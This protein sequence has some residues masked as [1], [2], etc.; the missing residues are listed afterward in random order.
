MRLNATTGLIVVI[1]GLMIVNYG[2][3]HD[4]IW[5]GAEVIV[6]GLQSY[7]V[8]LVGTIITLIGAGAIMRAGK[9]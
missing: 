9:P 4:L 7:L 6:M 5:Q 1:L 8:V 3:L 2:Y